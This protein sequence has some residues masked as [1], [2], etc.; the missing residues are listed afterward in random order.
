MRKTVLVAGV[1]AAWSL[2]QTPVS[3]QSQGRQVIGE[4][5]P[6]YVPLW[7]GGKRIGDSSI[8]QVQFGNVVVDV[9]AGTGI[10][11]ET[12]SD[13]G[14]GEGIF[15]RAITSPYGVGVRGDGGLHGIVGSAFGT[16]DV[17]FGLFPTG[18]Q[19]GAGAANGRG[20]AGFADGSGGIGVFGM[21][22]QNGV[23]AEASG[24]GSNSV[25]VNAFA[26]QSQFGIGVYGGGGRIG[27]IGSSQFC[28]DT[29]VPGGCAVPGVGGL[30][31]TGTGGEILLGQVVDINNDHTSVFRVDSTG[32]G[33]F[34][35]GTQVGGADFAE[36]VRVGGSDVSYGPG[37]LLVVDET[38]DRQIVLASRPYSTLVAGIYSTK[39]GILATPR[40]IGEAAAHAEVPMA[41]M[42]IVPCKVSAENGAIR[43]G[44]LLVTSSTPGHAM[45]GTNRGRML[46]AVVGK[47]LGSQAAGTGVIEVLVTLQ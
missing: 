26:V 25:G 10:W 42:G 3:A 14:I 41:V 30:F 39:P 27:V 45:K 37:D 24:Q 36:S 2:V 4:G 22:A 23:H 21:G 7:V 1:V 11:A 18:V 40:G 43:R 38:A 8:R 19:G 46:G 35:G 34:N 12:R 16:A 31:R 20:V 33:F 47:A 32:K 9:A 15:G 28:T 5:T 29:N 44:D 17:P 13:T 6:G